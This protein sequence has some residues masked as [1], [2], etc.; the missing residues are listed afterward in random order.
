MN[1]LGDFLAK[2]AD[3]KKP[4]QDLK[5]AIIE[6]VFKFSGYQLKS[7]QIKVSGRRVYL[8]ISPLVRGEIFVQKSKILQRLAATLNRHA[9]IDI[10]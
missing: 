7:E 10:L 9:P 8:Q 2:F 5:E 1:H 3:W 4:H 6:T